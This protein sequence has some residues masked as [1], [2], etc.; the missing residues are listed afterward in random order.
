MISRRDIPVAALLFAMVACLLAPAMMGKTFFIRDIAYLFHPWRT[1]AAQLIQSG[2]VPL[3]NPYGYSGMPFLANWQSAVFFPFSIVFSLFGFSRAITLYYALLLLTGGAFSYLFGRGA[4]FSR[5]SAVCLMLLATFSGFMLSKLEFLSY[6]GVLAFTFAP[7]LFIRKPL[8]MGLSLVIAFFAG[9]QAFGFLLAMAVF[10]A[11]IS[12]RSYANAA[13]GRLWL[14]S[15]GICLLIIAAQLIPTVELFLHTSRRQSGVDERS[16]VTNSLSVADM[17]GLLVRASPD[18][19]SGGE[20]MNWVSTLYVGVF[21]VALTLFAIASSSI[22]TRLGIGAISLFAFGIAMS[23][24]KH[25]IVFRFLYDHVPA[26]NLMRYPVQY[27]YFATV[28]IAVLAAIGC[29]RFKRV[30]VF[31]AFCIAVELVVMNHGFQPLA[32]DRFFDNKPSLAAALQAAGL[33]T[34]F[35]LS[36]GMETDRRIQGAGVEQAWTL[37][38]GSLYNAVSLPYRVMNAYGAGEPLTLSII[39]TNIDLLYRQRTPADVL[40]FLSQAGITHLISRKPVPDTP[41]LAARAIDGWYSYDVEDSLQ[42]VGLRNPGCGT[43]TL[44]VL[45]P[46]HIRVRSSL[47]SSADI[48]IVR[49]PVYPGWQAYVDGQRETL[50]TTENGYMGIDLKTGSA[51]IDLMYH[52]ASFSLG[53]LLSVLG[54]LTIMFMGIRYVCAA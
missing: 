23:L 11:L 15:G 3:W 43:I 49:Q 40:P 29:E 44:D 26:M 21:A 31:I 22:K 8:F 5:W 6:A 24:G 20:S 39:E 30:G 17:R 51:A 2:Q 35:I 18:E 13:R 1:Y 50:R 46:G 33:N 19:R 37:A 25:S 45:N 14:I 10:L 36:P 54:I 12:W 52:P 32:D 48:L 7:F 47:A 41:G 4:G 16:A 27:F 9:H 53:V 42:P 28:G 38:R 34:R